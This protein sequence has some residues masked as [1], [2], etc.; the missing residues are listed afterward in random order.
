MPSQTAHAVEARHQKF[1]I[2]YLGADPK[3]SGNGTACAIECGYSKR[4]AASIAS[5]LL[6]RL[7]IKKLANERSH[8]MLEETLLSS[9]RLLQ[10][11][12]RIAFF[13]P[14]KLY[15]PDG[16]IKQVTEMDDNTV[17]AISSFD[18]DEITDGRGS[19][20]KITGTSHKIRLHDKLQAIDKAMR[21]LGMFERD[22]KQKVESVAIS[23]NLVGAVMPTRPGD[24][25]RPVVAERTD[26]QQQI[27]DR[28][29]ARD[30]AE[31]LTIDQ[32]AREK[33][34]ALE[35]RKLK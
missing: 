13:D 20:S 34:A 27:T 33:K 25:A 35:R 21:M 24:D 29:P 5:Q 15:H 30:K 1:R 9:E 4:T 28:R 7:K 23:V 18:Q 12:S 26:H 31:P 8:E 3:F 14:R 22:N 17:A 6:S 19:K 10:E 2:L 11:L 32:Y 16:R